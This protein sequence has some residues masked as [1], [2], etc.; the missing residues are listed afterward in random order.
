MRNIEE[1]A[2]KYG[3]RVN[4]DKK[5]VDHVIKGLY[6]KKVV[7]GEEY[8]P[9]SALHNKNTICPCKDMRESKA[10]RCGLYLPI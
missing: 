3:M 6:N 4:P 1:I 5:R 2:E 10:C 8:C 7:H 9:C